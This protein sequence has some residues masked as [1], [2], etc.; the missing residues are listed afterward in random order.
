MNHQLSIEPNS[1]L[2]SAFLRVRTR[3]VRDLWSAGVLTG[4]NVRPPWI[5]HS[6]FRVPSSTRSIA[7]ILLLLLASLRSSFAADKT[8]Y[9]EHVLPLIEANCAKCHNEDKKKADLDLTSYSG[10]LRGS[11]SGPVLA[12][13]NVEGSKLWKALTHSEE[14]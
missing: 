4:R 10:A 8:T 2:L 6:P 7:V 5:G 14:P 1:S 11:G 9:Q 3:A 13:G 12:S